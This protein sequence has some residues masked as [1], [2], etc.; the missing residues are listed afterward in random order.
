MSRKEVYLIWNKL[1][2]NRV[3]IWG[4][5]KKSDKEETRGGGSKCDGTGDE[6]ENGDPDGQTQMRN[7]KSIN[8]REAPPWV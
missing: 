7:P 6:L 8:L 2:Q 5:Q 1:E 3:K 4:K